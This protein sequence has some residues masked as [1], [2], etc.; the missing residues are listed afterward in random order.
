MWTSVVRKTQDM[1]CFN[2]GVHITS[3]VHIVYSYLTPI[4]VG[5]PWKSHFSE[6]FRPMHSSILDP[7]NAYFIHKCTRLHTFASL[8]LIFPGRHPQTPKLKKGQVA[9]PDPPCWRGSTVPHFQSFA[10]AIDVIEGH[11]LNVDLL[12]S[13]AEQ[14][15]TV[16]R[17][18]VEK[19]LINSTAL[20]TRC[21]KYKR[22]VHD[23]PRSKVSTWA[24]EV[25][26][27]NAVCHITS[28]AY[29]WFTRGQHRSAISGFTK[30][31]QSLLILL[32][33]GLTLK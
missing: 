7:T 11:R 2:R 18:W 10:P 15:K 8:F 23:R 1:L 14:Y 17:W 6:I 24:R 16:Q 20:A 12:D 26:T 13:S 32:P 25:L 29:L 22:Q 21:C 9:F 4:P 19:A 5:F 27:R 28:L 33:N 30:L 3:S 31:L